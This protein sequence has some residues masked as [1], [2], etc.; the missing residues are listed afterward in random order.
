MQ[1]K[2]TFRFL[3]A[4]LL[5]LMLSACGGGGGGSALDNTVNNGSGNGSTTGL[6][7][8][9]GTGSSFV[10]GAIT[11]TASSPTL[12][13]GDKT[14]LSVSIVDGQGSPTTN[15]VKVKFDSP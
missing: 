9:S 10:S 15:I 12:F 8:G 2:T 7:I 1:T 4:S 13:E 3:S 11:S 14:Q 6:R 5:S